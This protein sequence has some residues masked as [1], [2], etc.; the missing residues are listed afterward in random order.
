[1]AETPLIKLTQY[2]VQ[3]IRLQEDKKLK[4]SGREAYQDA[5][6]VCLNALKSVC[7]AEEYE[8]FYGQVKPFLK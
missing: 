4:V 1:M 3:Q 6:E 2:F 8:I 5:A 7:N